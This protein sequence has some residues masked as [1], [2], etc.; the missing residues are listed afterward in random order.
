MN[1]KN[2]LFWIAFVG[3]LV[4]LATLMREFIYGLHIALF[5]IGLVVI[6]LTLK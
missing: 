4:V 3:E 5:L 2:P 6:F 1:F